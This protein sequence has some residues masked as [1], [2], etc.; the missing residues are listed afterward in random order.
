MKWEFH[1]PAKINSKYEE[2]MR[3]KDNVSRKL[4]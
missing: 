3:S 1:F 2:M 4:Y